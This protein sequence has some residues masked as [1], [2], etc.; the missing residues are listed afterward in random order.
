M[1]ERELSTDPIIDL[2]R[3]LVSLNSR[4]VSIYSPIVDQIIIQQSTDR[5]LIESTLDG[6]LGFAGTED[7]LTLYKRLCRYYWDL[8]P[9]ATASYISAYRKMWDEESPDE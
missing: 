1:S 6:L 8:A 3:Q 7:G 2:A 9:L 5:S 4:A